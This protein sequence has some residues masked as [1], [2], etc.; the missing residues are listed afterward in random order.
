MPMPGSRAIRVTLLTVRG[1]RMGPTGGT[2]AMTDNLGQ[3][4]TSFGYPLKE[5]TGF[6]SLTSIWSYLGQI[7][8]GTLSEILIT[9]YRIPRTLLLTLNILLSSVSHILIAFNVPGGL[10]VASVINGFCSGAFWSLIFTIISELFGLKHYSTLYHFGTV[11]SPIGLYFLN[12]KVTGYYY[13]KEAKKQ[14]A[15]SGAVLKPGEALNCLGGECFKMSF[16][17][18]TV[19]ALFGAVVSLVLVVRTTKFYHGDIYKKFRNK[20]ETK[21]EEDEMLSSVA[22][23]VGVGQEEGP[24]NK[25]SSG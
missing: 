19:V 15:A 6:V 22:E 7:T 18:I 17:I 20:A 8:A 13:D 5:I 11:A 3:I 9:K 4:G 12:V 24:T 2:K 1:S 21:E 23:S 14:M 10:Y 16:I 25:R